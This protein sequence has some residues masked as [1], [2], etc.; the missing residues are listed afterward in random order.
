MITIGERETK[1]KAQRDAAL[2]AVAI[3]AGEVIEL[4]AANGEELTTALRDE[5]L[6]K[7]AAGEYVE[8]TMEIDAY[9]QKTGV[10]NRNFVRIHDQDLASFATSGKGRP[11]LKDHAQRDTM[12]KCGVIL[13]SDLNEKRGMDNVRLKVRL[14][15]IWA[16]EAALRNLLDTVSVSWRARGPVKCDACNEAV[17]SK[18]WHLPGDKLR[19]V[20]VDGQ[21]VLTR[22]RNGDITVQWVYYDP[23]MLECSFVPVPAVPTSRIDTIRASIAD[24]FD[25]ADLDIPPTQET[26]TMSTAPDLSAQL[27]A[28]IA[29]YKKIVELSIDERLY[30]D[31]Q[32]KEVQAEF[33]AKSR[34]ERQDDMTPVYE[35]SNGSKF[36]ASD[37]PRIVQQAKDQDKMVKD[38]KEQLSASKLAT[39]NARADKELAHLA[40]TTEVRA[41]ILGAIENIENPE[42]RAAALKAVTEYDGAQSRMFGRQGGQTKPVTTNAEEKL[43]QKVD[44]YEKEHDCDSAEA[45]NAVL[46]TDEGAKLYAESEEQKKA[47]RHN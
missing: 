23:E 17:F 15:A 39:L 30:F 42:I 24:L 40:G 37:D 21:K 18:C 44:A 38:L 32:S 27:N 8:L 34:K 46:E 28:E 14:T 9:Q 12:S 20:I 36:F 19:A 47:A 11:F 5:M 29:R 3:F 25:N 7:C 16:V 22:D 35:A 33:L 26:P 4:R 45:W 6:K 10:F 43:Q 1:L 41:S 13:S 31:R 2:S